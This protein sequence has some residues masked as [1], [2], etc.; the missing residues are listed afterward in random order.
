MLEAVHSH[1]PEIY[2]FC[3]SAYSQP[4]LLKYGDRVIYSR[5]GVQQGDPLGPLLFSLTIHPLLT[6]LTSPFRI[7][8]LDD[9]TLGGP[10]ATVADDIEKVMVGGAE[11]GLKLN[12]SKCEI[13]SESHYHGHA[14]LDSFI[15]KTA[16]QAELLGASLISG[17]AMISKLE[18][19][20]ADLQRASVRLMG[21]QRHDALILLRHSLSA[22]KVMHTLR[23]S[24][25]SQHPLLLILDKILRDCL[26]NL[27][28]SDLSEDQWP[29]ASLPVRRGGLC[30]RSFSQLAPSAFLSSYNAT[31]ELQLLI[32]ANCATSVGADFMP[33]LSLRGAAN[34]K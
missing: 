15:H 9:L 21:I 20:S 33:R 8:Y 22:P 32:L 17:D 19:H 10:D 3:S 26:C 23:T 30:I 27:L 7:G 24:P 6:D 5:E 29:Q 34:S 31:R 16:S 25:C 4:T 12:I 13:I 18:K 2:S 11:L 28:N 14:L 1:F